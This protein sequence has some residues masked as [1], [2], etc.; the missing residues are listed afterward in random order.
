MRC[1][2]HSFRGRSAILGELRS[3]AVARKIAELESSLEP[4]KPTRSKPA[5]QLI[6]RPARVLFSDVADPAQ[7]SGGGVVAGLTLAGAAASAELVLKLAAK[8]KSLASKRETIEA[9]LQEVVAHRASFEE[10][11]DRDMAAF[12][13]LVATQRE[14]KSLRETDPH[15]AHSRLQ[16]AYVHAAQVP[17]SLSQEATVFMARVEAG[18]EFASRFTI[19][20]LGAAAAL[21]RG[22][23]DAALLTVDAN[24]AYVE[25]ERADQLRGQVKEARQRADEIANR[26]VTRAV[27]V[28][29][30][31]TKGS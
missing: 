7:N 3:R 4:Y 6:D 23:I 26:V 11:A 2:V 19:S 10:A 8:R 12:S 9:L 28:I 20:D 15:A 17:L 21:A 13:E 25:D 16:D 1:T 27:N 30:A 18:L 14:A 24:L 5:P 29:T 31:G 22:A